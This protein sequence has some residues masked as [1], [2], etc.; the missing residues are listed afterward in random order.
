MGQK[1]MEKLLDAAAFWVKT[2][3]YSVFDFSR[4]SLYWSWKYWNWLA[5]IIWLWVGNTENDVRSWVL[6]TEPKLFS[7]AHIRVEFR[8][9]EGKM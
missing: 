3:K 1:E 2:T 6:S 5:A 4:L 8:A 7:R 9:H